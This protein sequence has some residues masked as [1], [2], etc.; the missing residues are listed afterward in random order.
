MAE[1]QDITLLECNRKSSIQNTTD[2][3]DNSIFTNRMGDVVQLDVGDTVELKSAFINK[4][5]CADPKSLEFKGQQ[6]GAKGEYLETRK[7]REILMD[8]NLTAKLQTKPN[9]PNN[10]D[11]EPVNTNTTQSRLA[12]RQI[13]NEKREYDLKDNELNLETNFYKNTNG[14]GYFHH[15]RKYIRPSDFAVSGGFY[16]RPANVWNRPDCDLDTVG[17][18]KLLYSAVATHDKGDVSG[19]CKYSPD[20]TIA[21][22]INEG[23]GTYDYTF[24]TNDYHNVTD[25]INASNDTVVNKQKSFNPVESIMI[26][27]FGRSPTPAEQLLGVRKLGPKY[28]RIK[29]KN[30]NSRYTMFEREYD[31][32]RWPET[33]V[34]NSNTGQTPPKEPNYL[35]G[36]TY[37]NTEN[38]WRWPELLGAGP[39]S[40]VPSRFKRPYFR[41]PAM[42][43]YLKKSKLIQVQVEEGFSSPQAVAD[44]ITEQLQKQ[45][46]DSPEI[47][48]ETEN[49]P[50]VS[51][52]VERTPYS[53]A[54]TTRTY[55]TVECANLKDCSYDNYPSY[56]TK[57]EYD[58]AG[59]PQ[60]SFEWFRSFHN[61]GIK[62]PDLYEAGNGVNN[63]YG[64]IPTPD[65]QAIGMD[66]S[67]PTGNQ[68]LLLGS[69]TQPNYIQNA[70]PMD[71]VYKNNTTSSMTTSWIYNTKNLEA[72]QNLFDI[73]GKYPELF[74]DYSKDYTENKVFMNKELDADGNVS[75]GEVA[76]IDNSRFLHINRF[77]ESTNVD[78]SIYDGR[79]MFNI[80]GDDGYER[81]SYTT[82]AG[83]GLRTFDTDHRAV[84]FFFKYDKTFRNVDTA[85]YDETR[86]SYGFA[87]KTKIGGVYY[88]VLHP[89][90]VNG[91]RPD[92]FLLRGG[93]DV[94]TNPDVAPPS[95]TKVKT[96]NSASITANKCMI[97]WDHHF[98]SWGNVTLNQFT[99]NMLQAF[100]GSYQYGQDT[101]AGYVSSLT[102]T[103]RSVNL[104]YLGANNVACV[105]DA[106]S[107]KFGFEYLH[108]PEYIGN[109]FDSGSTDFIDAKD[110]TA[111][112][113]KPIISDA[114]NEVYKINKRLH[115]WT[116]CPDM[117][118]YVDQSGEITSDNTNIGNVR[119]DPIN[120]NLSP[121]QI[122]DSHM[123]VTFNFGKSA[124]VDTRKY[125]VSQ[126]TLWNNSVLGIMGFSYDQ[127]NPKIIDASNNQQARLRFS[128]IRNVYNP[129]TNSQVVNT[130][131]NQFNT[132]PFGAIQYT[133][134]LPLG[135]VFEI[136]NPSTWQIYKAGGTPPLSTPWGYLPAISQQTSSIKIEG[137]NPPKTILRPYLTIRSDLLSQNK[138]IGGATS[139]L[140]MPI[141]AVVNHINAEKDYIQ[142]EGSDVFTVTHPIKFSSITTA[143]CDPDGTL[144]L[145]D[146]GSAVIYKITKLNNLSKYD[147]KQEWLEGLKKK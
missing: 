29:Q 59:G 117:A 147:I 133:T 105:Y 66:P 125:D 38:W 75:F 123:G 57:S 21:Y 61:I 78:Q 107:G 42:Y 53:L 119:L 92:V 111:G 112:E 144:S 8:Y 137:V 35:D 94:F 97:G 142:L 43:P 72:L 46:I 113:E 5:G 110:K 52:G 18:D 85:G 1:F 69:F 56:Y 80:L 71:A 99:G 58:K 81:F 19:E 74:Y 102:G 7:I 115:K 50:A 114:G 64:R 108:M 120:L 132:N 86:L 11:N 68:D 13:V 4:R 27:E 87:T 37:I 146:D 77:D 96:W 127:F 33:P 6:I 98:T 134:Q 48:D 101:G 28:K 24:N 88:I 67:V 2:D 126:E 54:Y 51:G 90:L 40:N 135:L 49:F 34:T 136:T 129:T 79:N 84:P 12:F 76:S 121:W 103:D 118:P 15:P 3:I 139:G 138:Y 32:L 73:Q 141:M 62:R 93:A 26:C 25:E 145:L 89:E 20:Y 128:N 143:I 55:E 63:Y 124:E 10:P 109:D 65:K 30:D 39:L 31:W 36:F 23:I 131:S 122:Y 9:D 100:D 104:T 82:G 106:I 70:M 83:A 116:F 47:F 95:M 44:Q 16:E 17:K 41:S 91:L 140:K 45:D 22:G 130:D 60:K 14:E